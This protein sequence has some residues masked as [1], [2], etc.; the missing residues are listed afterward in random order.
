MREIYTRVAQRLSDNA[1]T[2]GA[3][4]GEVN[5]YNQ[6]NATGDTANVWEGNSTLVLMP[7]APYNRLDFSQKADTSYRKGDTFMMYFSTSFCYQ[8]GSREAVVCLTIT[9][10]NDSVV[11]KV[12]HITTN[13]ISQIYAPVMED[14]CAKGFIYLGPGSEKSSTLKMMYISQ[15]QLIRFHQAEPDTAKTERQEIKL[16]PDTLVRN[17]HGTDSAGATIGGKS[18]DTGDIPSSNAAGT[19]GRAAGVGGDST[20][21]NRPNKLKPIRLGT[22]NKP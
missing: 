17:A 5:R 3:A 8:S 4:E 10:D 14:H 11:S 7:Y 22:T 12:N 9:Y 13:G 15:L 2:L 19:A 18:G 16:A 20:F 6:L 1:V 21:K